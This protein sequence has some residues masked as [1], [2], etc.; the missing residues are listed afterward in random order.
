MN[1]EQKRRKGSFGRIGKLSLLCA[2]GAMLLSGCRQEER[3][4]SPSP[5]PGLEEPARAL[6]SEPMPLQQV[7]LATE[8][9]VVWRKHAGSKPSLLL[10]SDQPMLHPVPDV[11][12]EE[13][14]RFISTA[15]P[16][17]IVRRTH[18]AGPD[19]LMLPGMTIDG[20]LRAGWFAR[21]FWALPLRDADQELFLDPFR[22]KLIERGFLNDEEG[23]SLTLVDRR[24][25]GQIRGVPFVAAPFAHLPDIAGPVIVHID[26][27]YFQK[28]Y[29]NEVA[30]PLLK[31][32]LGALDSLRQRKIPVLAVTL[33]M[34]NLEGR[35]GLD[36]RFLGEVIRALVETPQIFDGPLPIT[37]RRQGDILYLRDFF[38]KD[39][40]REV[41]LAMER[42]EPR[43]AA[44]KFSL[45][46]SAVEF[47]DGVAALAYLG[48]AA[49]LDRVYAL[50][51]LD[52]AELA[53]ERGRPDEA[54]RMLKLAR[55][56]MPSNPEIRLRQAQLAAQLGKTGEAARL[57]EELS[58]LP[59]SPV[60]FPEMKAELTAF[61]HSLRQQGVGEAVKG[62]D[63]EAPIAKR[64]S[65]YGRRGDAKPQE[66]THER[67]GR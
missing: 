50:E 46:R 65:L 32:T 15:S 55:S 45:Y 11:L 54:V 39:E 12:R 51:Y 7:E 19:L 23:E 28:L 67:G 24:Y 6:F 21:F 58:A 64:R 9:L 53:A 47:R 42:D 41:A 36:V 4:V 30:T 34:G 60:Y 62:R 29:K 17:E 40:I 33:S 8:A 61:A 13:A 10:L 25:A 2:V 43:S 5:A 38:Q 48:Q 20:A 3:P 26:L 66:G 1:P 57:A 37:W 14:T 35:I 63:G 59:W 18:P 44:V 52:L 49:A 22:N 31:T 16:E 56:A 27:S